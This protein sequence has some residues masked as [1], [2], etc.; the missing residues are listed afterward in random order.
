[1]SMKNLVGILNCVDFHSVQKKTGFTYK[2]LF[3]RPQIVVTEGEI[4]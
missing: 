2:Y 4:E 3:D 1:M